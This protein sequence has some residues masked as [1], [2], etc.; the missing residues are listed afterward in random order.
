MLAF[1]HVQQSGS[2]TCTYTLLSHYKLTR[3]MNHNIPITTITLVKYFSIYK[4]TTIMHIYS[5]CSKWSLAQFNPIIR[6]ILHIDII[7]IGQGQI[8]AHSVILDFI[9]HITM[10]RL[11]YRRI[12]SHIS[13]RV[14]ISR[15]ARFPI[16][17]R[18]SNRRVF[19]T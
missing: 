11:S 17:I 8:G 5:I 15:I 2:P 18:I 1:L 7:R 13:Y 12:S 6:Q 16:G 9:V 19:A 14:D 3:F 4:P 10:P